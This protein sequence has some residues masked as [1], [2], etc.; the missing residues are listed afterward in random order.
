M[1]VQL[2]KKLGASR[3]IGGASHE[4]RRALAHRLGAD[5]TVD[6][7]RADWPERVREATGGRGADV[8]FVS[9]GGETGARS[10]QAL[11]PRGRLVL[12]GAESMFDTQ[13]GREQ[14]AGLIARNQSVSGFATFTLPQE[15]L[16]A[17]LLEVLALVQRG[18]LSV[19]MGAPRP[20]EAVAQ[21][22][23]DMAARKTE[24]KVVFRVA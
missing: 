23:R 14:M 2:A 18:E 19:V 15:E 12:F 5:A 1:L 21:A 11:A 8:V 24:G 4:A 17:A 20:L 16:R 22:H 6:T 3:V 7:S 13:L 10:L 9:G